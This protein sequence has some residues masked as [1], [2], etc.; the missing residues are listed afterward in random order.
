M[1]TKKQ[2]KGITL[3]KTIPWILIVTGV[4]AIIM[5]GVIIWEKVQMLQNPAYIP[6]CNLN[7][8]ISC[9]PVTQS[10]QAAA[11]GFP[12]PLVGLVAFPVIVT[13]GVVLLSGATL[14]K[15]YWL[16]LEFG[17]IFGIGFIHWL[18]FETVYR[19][20]ALCPYCMVV[21]VMTFILFIYISL[22]NFRAGYIKLPKYL[23][24]VEE[25][26]QKHHID[27]IILW[28]LVIAGLIL[29]HFWYYYR[30]RIHL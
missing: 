21:W 13:T 18:F 5:S 8:V 20:H 27:I 26:I 22:Y 29:K 24:P 12:N 10:K 14:K 28:I 15:W 6:N 23:K 17:T 16:G 30:T 11:F 7:P 25:F 2:P 9:G 3:E 4:I 19:I 1:A